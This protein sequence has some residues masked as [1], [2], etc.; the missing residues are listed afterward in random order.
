MQS[1]QGPVL[2]I[3]TTIMHCKRCIRTNS[4]GSSVCVCV[5]EY[6][7]ICNLCMCECEM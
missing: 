7:P 5:G 6:T 2:M 4:P 3:F 1:G